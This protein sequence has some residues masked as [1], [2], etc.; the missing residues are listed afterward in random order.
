M[1]FLLFERFWGL[2]SEVWVLKTLAFA[3]MVGSVMTLIERSGGVNGL[4]HELST[5]RSLVSSKRGALMPSFIAGLIIF[6]ESSITSLVAGAIGRPFCDKYGISRAKLAFVCDSTS[7][8]VCS[9]IAING[10]GALLLGLIG[11]QIAAGLIA[12]EEARWLISAI[13][14]NFYAYIALIVTFVAI[15]YNI[16]IGPMKHAAI[17][18]PSIECD[19]EQGSVGLFVWPMVWMIGGVLIFMLITGDGNLL[20]GSGSSSIFYTLI[21]TLFMMY[22]YYQFKNAMNTTD[23]ISA[24]FQGAK[25]MAPIASILLLAFAIGGISSDMKVG[26]YLASFIGDYLPSAYLPAAIFVLSAIIAFATG[27]SWG[28][29]SIMLPIAVPL[30]V[31]LDAPVALA[32]GA[33]I[34]G[35]VFGDHCS[36]ISDTTII[37]AMASGC[38]VQEH[39][40]TQLPYAL[41]SAAIALPLFI[42]MGL[43]LS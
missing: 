20:K 12:G 5:K 39:T 41:I 8:P 32:M 31:G 22:G 30:A 26:Q 17:T 38:S 10:W 29:F 27:T 6:I 21:V 28:T 19:D 37:S 15:W 42:I 14:Y 13:G 43:I 2:L 1:L 36:P 35:G 3:M 25:S 11:G 23:F 34:S 7:A 4:V 24:A 40:R 16:D 9:I 33:V 18:E